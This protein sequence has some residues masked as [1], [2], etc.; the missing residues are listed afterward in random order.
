MSETA[1]SPARRDPRRLLV[2]AG[3]ALLVLA[4]ATLAISSMAVKSVTY[5]EAAHL[6]AGLAMLET[7]TDRLNPQ[8]PPLVKLLAGAAAATLEPEV[9]LGG[10]AYRQGRQWAFGRQLLFASGND[11][12]E[13]L[14]RGRLP[15][16]GLSVLGGVA[17]F[18]W[19]R[20][21]FGDGGGLFSLALYA[22][23]PTVL[24]HG[25]LVTM[26]VAVATFFT[27]TLYLWWRAVRG[28]ERWAEIAA[29]AALG[30]ALAA[31][32]SGLV[33]LPA[34]VLTD[35]AATGWRTDWRR[36]LE[37]WGVVLPVAGVCLWVLYLC[38]T[39]PRFYY[40][41]VVRIYADI[42][43]GY[44]FYL[45]GEFSPDGFPHY[46]LV[47]MALKSALPGLVAMVAGL[48]VAAWRRERWRD[49]VFLWLP[50]A[51]WLAVTSVAA[52]DMGVRYA[53]TAYPLL[54]V[55][56]GGLVPVVTS[57]TARG[58]GWL[59]VLVALAQASTAVAAHPDYIPFFNRVAGGVRAGPHWLDDSNVDWGQDL[60]RLPGWLEAHGVPAVRL[61]Y[62]GQG[63][64]LHYGVPMLPFYESDFRVSP[65]PGA[66][67][68][69]AH[70][71]ARGLYLA[72][73]QGAASDWLVRYEPVDV[74]GGSLYLYVFP[75]PEREGEEPGR[76][77]R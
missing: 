67:V 68:V 19:A 66:Y 75:P 41:G 15:M 31:K 20:R 60:A 73:H 69:S 37:R 77:E 26:D 43:P 23:S 28:A 42:R 53:L 58:A 51:L 22:F 18:V 6:P 49:D 50:A 72:R 39:D 10:E 9:P 24:A 29:G 74:L 38:P 36:R 5:D 44:P 25:R 27:A 13:L 4:H 35:L 14:F 56:A 21:R 71:L 40:E 55:L 47:A 48:G 1:P 76:V 2:S 33:A 63:D 52:A 46:F 34:M 59:V 11:D 7:G 65:R 62:F 54:F 3:A 57:L 32:F 70:L 30:L 61:H 17:V 12:A 8:H 64:P 45:A 16:V